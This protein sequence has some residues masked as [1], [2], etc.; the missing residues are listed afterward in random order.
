M[1][2]NKTVMSN[3]LWRFLEKFGAEIV[4][5]VVGVILARLLEPKVYG[6]IALVTVFSTLLSVL[7]DSGFGTALIQKKEVDDLDYSTVFW[8]NMVMSIVVYLVLFFLA[9]FIASYYEMPE[10]KLIV[11]IQCIQIL[12][13]GL[14]N[15]QSSYVA[16]NMMF[17]KFFFSTLTGTIGS[18]VVGVAIAYMGCAVCA[19]VGQTLSI[20]LFNALVLFFT[21]NWRPKFMFSFERMK[22]MFSFGWKLLVSS[23]LNRAY[24]ELRQLIIGKM[25]STADLAY[26]NRGRSYPNL[27]V[28]QI[29]TAID[30]V[31]LSAMSKEQKNRENIKN[32]TR[33]S[34]SVCTYVM[35][36][37]MAGLAV[38]SEPLVALLL[39]EKWLPAVPYMQIAS[40]ICAFTPM[41]TANLNAIKALGRSDLFL[42]LEVIKKVYGLIILLLTFRISVMAMAWS[43]LVTTVLGLLV[44]SFPNK[45]LLDYTFHDQIKDVFPS[46]VM[47]L[48]MAV[49]TY[50]I[51]FLKLNDWLTLLI[52]VP[53]GAG[54]Y[55]GLSI[56]TQN[57]TF[58]FLFE[59]VSGMLSKYKF[60]KKKSEE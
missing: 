12:I 42:K 14:N 9:P 19:R 31:L 29:I 7:V 44:N 59:T 8:F 53:L 48:V 51:H 58:T 40:I 5:F 21:I 49:V 30:S 34:I 50:S 41:Q 45:K 27:V 16:K 46:L 25:Y 11:R 38:C 18:A 36:P 26:Y 1:R 57:E 55:F 2:Q 52:Q 32:M 20:S 22:S 60:F 35:F 13:S 39:T 37:M 10:L 54:I 3:V 56:M 4:T 23:M 17:K 24:N 33:R 43:M 6:T 28:N 15:I 47:T